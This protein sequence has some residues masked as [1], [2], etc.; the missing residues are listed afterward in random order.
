LGF[1]LC[2]GNLHEVIDQISGEGDRRPFHETLRQINY[3][4]SYDSNAHMSR[5][6]SCANE[7]HRR[8][9]SL[10]PGCFSA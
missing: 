7:S 10:L 1:V 9:V 4:K 8:M 6:K 5:G 3:T 2:P